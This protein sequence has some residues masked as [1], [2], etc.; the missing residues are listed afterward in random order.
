MYNQELKIKFVRS[1]TTSISMAKLCET[2]FNQT[3]EFEFSWGADLCT[4]TIKDLQPM[5]N[6]IAGFRAKSSY[7]IL[8]V[9]KDYVKWCVGT[10]VS[11]ARPDM[12]KIEATGL[13]NL[14]VQM[15][16]M[17]KHLQKY[18]D[19]VFEAE[20]CKTV[21]NVYR[22]FYWLAYSGMREHEILEVKSSEVDFQKMTVRHNGK[23]Y[24]IYRE[25]IQ[26][27]RNCV[28]LSGFS[29]NHPLYT[30]SRVMK[31]ADSD[32]LLRGTRT[33][34]SSKVMRATLSKRSKKALEDGS[35]T[36]K[37]S[38]YRV[39][40]SGLFF[41]EYEREK[42]GMPVDFTEAASRFVEGREYKL[43]KGKKTLAAKKREVAKDYLEDYQRWKLAFFL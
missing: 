28:S 40:L 43:E 16:A 21:D 12:L 23:E 14:K 18:L 39:W 31:R 30:T 29:Y 35:T 15:V 3:E 25:A 22:C 11:G 10:G 5:V 33:I 8:I 2:V 26:A 7:A 36:Q 37:L 41:R 42:S 6:S 27:F 9:L 32:L 19:E 20:D 24:I 1:Y 4:R 13:E 38:Y 34:F 17:P